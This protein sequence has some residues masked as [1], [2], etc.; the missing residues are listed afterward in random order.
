MNFVSIENNDNLI[1]GGQNYGCAGVHYLHFYA[2][3][4]KFDLDFRYLA[5]S[6][7]GQKVAGIFHTES[8]L[9][10][11][12]NPIIFVLVVGKVRMLLACTED[13]QSNKI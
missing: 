4:I 11:S 6:I 3:S 8:K 9:L 10:A 1:H 7:A 13:K 5:H 12:G 2:K